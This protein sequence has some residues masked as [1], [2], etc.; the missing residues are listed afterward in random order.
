[1][2]LHGVTLIDVLIPIGD[3]W[4]SNGH[5]AKMPKQRF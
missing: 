1:M 4:I 2:A 5:A 3:A